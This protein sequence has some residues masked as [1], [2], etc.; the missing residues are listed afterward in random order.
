MTEYDFTLKFTLANEN[1]D[2]QAYVELLAEAGCEDAMIGIGQ[3]GRIALQFFREAANAFDAVLTAIQD[4]KSVLPNACLVEAT[5]DLVGLSDIGDL[6][7]CSRQNMRKLM[8]AHHQSFPAPIHEGKSSIWHLFEVLTWFEQ[9]QNKSVPEALL[10][11]ADANMQ[12]NLARSSVKL[13]PLFH[14]KVSGLMA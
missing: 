11:I 5:P 12:L 6:L 8:L 7:D 13:D 9:H 10:T 14:A 1:A 4:V 2:P 3:K